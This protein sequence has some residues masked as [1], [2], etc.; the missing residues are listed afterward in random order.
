MY[1]NSVFILLI[2]IMLF[3]SP[4]SYAETKISYDLAVG[5]A[6]SANFATSQVSHTSK[7]SKYKK[8]LVKV[9]ANATKN[10]IQK[11]EAAGISSNTTRQEIDKNM[12][13][14]AVVVSIAAKH[15]IKNALDDV[16][17]KVM[18]NCKSYYQM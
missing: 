12:R 4:F 11:G 13:M 15:G 2:T 17:K 7:Y 1:T 16:V 14:D 8:I 6:G 10:A 18:N 3:T 9:G 5:C